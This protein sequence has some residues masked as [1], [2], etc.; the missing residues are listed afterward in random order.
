MA[1][2]R[3]KKASVTPPSDASRLHSTQGQNGIAKSKSARP[4]PSVK[5][6]QR[7][8]RLTE[9]QVADIHTMLSSHGADDGWR[10]VKEFKELRLESHHLISHGDGNDD[11]SSLVKRTLL[12]FNTPMTEVVDIK[13][14]CFALAKLLYLRNWEVND[15][16]VKEMVRGFPNWTEKFPDLRKRVSLYRQDLQKKIWEKGLVPFVEENARSFNTETG[17]DDDAHGDETTPGGH[18]TS[19][20]RYRRLTDEQKVRFTPILR[21]YLRLSYHV[22]RPHS[23]LTDR[24]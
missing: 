17:I 20:S 2:I 19:N 11:I 21:S 13:K 12:L 16:D 8:P 3:P 23:G 5:T 24:A 6:Q 9:L 1:P 15:Q 18:D 7:P 22:T 4:R 10:V 14:H